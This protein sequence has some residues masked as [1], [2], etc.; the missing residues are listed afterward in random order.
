MHPKEW[1]TKKHI[2]DTE[3]NLLIYI[4]IN[5]MYAHIRNIYSM[6]F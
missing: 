4:N 5:I 2:V 6:Q 3:I 1:A